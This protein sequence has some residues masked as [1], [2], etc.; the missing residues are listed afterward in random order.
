MNFF[1]QPLPSIPQFPPKKHTPSSIDGFGK[2]FSNNE[3]ELVVLGF[4]RDA[5]FFGGDLDATIAWYGKNGSL[6]AFLGD[7]E[8]QVFSGS[9]D[10]FN[11]CGNSSNYVY[12]GAGDDVL[13]G[14]SKFNNLHGGQWDDKLFFGQG[15]L[16]AGGQGKDHFVVVDKDSQLHTPT[17]SPVFYEKGMPSSFSPPLPAPPV[18]VQ[19]PTQHITIKDLSFLEGDVLDL[20]LFQGLSRENLHHVD[21]SGILSIETKYQKIDLH[22]GHEIDLFGGIDNLI[23]RGVLLVGGVDGGSYGE[24]MF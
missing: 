2:V 6:T 12:G 18:V 8:N 9:G 15:H 24:G 14:G 20:K 22:V 16:V 1:S 19:K 3:S 11:F 17:I 5:T 7:G 4:G 23:W 21:N 13:I 10:D